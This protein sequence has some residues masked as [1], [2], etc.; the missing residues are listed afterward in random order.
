MPAQQRVQE[1]WYQGTADAVFQ[2]LDILKANDPDYVLILAG[3]HV[4]KMDYGRMLAY[5]VSR[6]ADM[7][8]ACIEVPLDE[9][10]RLRRDGRGRGLARAQ[11]SDEKPPNPPPIPGQPGQAL[12]SMGIYVFNAKFLYEQVARDT[13]DPQLVA[14]T[15]AR[16]SSRTW[17]RATACSRTASRTAAWA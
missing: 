6:Q 16:T 1:H 13:D 12:A 8:V 11:L 17:C 15:S 10:T 4:Y 2:N 3:D 5:H 14:T 9:A 7:T